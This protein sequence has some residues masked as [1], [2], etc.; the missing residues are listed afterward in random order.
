MDRIAGAIFAAEL[1][2]AREKSGHAKAFLALLISSTECAE[3][4]AGLSP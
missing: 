2:W 1:A 4:V 3:G